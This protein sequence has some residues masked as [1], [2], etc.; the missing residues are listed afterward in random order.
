MGEEQRDEGV[1][2]VIG[3]MAPSTRRGYDKYVSSYKA[4]HG[5]RP[6]DL[7]G[8]QDW[9]V[10][11][12]KEENMRASTIKTAVSL[13]RKYLEVERKVSISNWRPLYSLVKAMGKGQVP[14]KSTAFPRESI[15]SYLKNG[16]FE[17]E[18]LVKKNVIAIGFFG[19]LRVTE[20]VGLRFGDIEIEEAGLRVNIAHSKT[21]QSGVGDHVIIA[22]NESKSPWCPVQ[23][24]EQLREAIGARAESKETRLFLQY[25][26]G[27]KRSESWSARQL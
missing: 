3:A 2:I 14:D 26:W 17:G 7:Q 18:E 25:R 5:E 16:G 12:Y 19:G 1:D 10:H 20:L 6:D 8:L 27:R 15:E 23:L 24:F 9:M 21:D 22:R 11:L 4:F 13:V